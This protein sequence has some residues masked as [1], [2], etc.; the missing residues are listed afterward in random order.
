M[1]WK[2]SSI[3]AIMVPIGTR[4][5]RQTKC[6]FG[7][8]ALLK[9]S[10]RASLLDTITSNTQAYYFNVKGAKKQICDSERTIVAD[11]YLFSVAK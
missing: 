1:M 6:L 2:K 8:A 9:P 5:P 7:E 4:Q 10:C 11:G 3:R